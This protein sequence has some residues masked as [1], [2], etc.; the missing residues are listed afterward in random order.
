MGKRFNKQQPE[1]EEMQ[2]PDTCTCNGCWLPPTQEVVQGGLRLYCDF[3]DRS[4]DTAERDRKTHILRRNESLVNHYYR[5]LRNK[6]PVELMLDEE[7]GKHPGV[8]AGQ[9]LAIWNRKADE[10]WQQYKQRYWL[11]LKHLINTGEN[12]LPLEEEAA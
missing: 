11:L 8:I 9:N 7:A 12:S 2:Q 1:I 4:D 5:N 3:H 6:T 10:N